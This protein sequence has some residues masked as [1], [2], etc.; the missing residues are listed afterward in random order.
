VHGRQEVAGE[1]PPQHCHQEQEQKTDPA[2][3]KAVAEAEEQSATKEDRQRRPHGELRAAGEEHPTLLLRHQTPHPGAP[4][5]LYQ[6][7]A[8]VVEDHQQDQWSHQIGAAQRRQRAEAEHQR[9][10]QH[11][12]HDHQRPP[13]QETAKPHGQQLQQ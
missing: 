10:L 11:G 1:G 2:E 6:V 5:R 9:G 4:L 13:R 12:S 3:A 8:G 7:R